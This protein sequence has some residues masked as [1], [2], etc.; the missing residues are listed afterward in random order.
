MAKIG[1]IISGIF[2]FLEKKEIPE[3]EDITE[4][5]KDKF[6]ASLVLKLNALGYGFDIIEAESN[7]KVTRAMKEM[8]ISHEHKKTTFNPVNK[9]HA[10]IDIFDEKTWE[11]TAANSI[12]N[13][14]KVITKL[15]ELKTKKIHHDDEKEPLQ[16]SIDYT[17]IARN[18]TEILDRE[19]LGDSI[20]RDREK[21]LADTYF[22]GNVARLRRLQKLCNDC[23]ERVITSDWEDIVWREN[24]NIDDISINEL[25]HT[26]DS[27]AERCCNYYG[28]E[29]EKIIP[30]PTARIEN[31]K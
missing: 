28:E 1:H 18:F 9:T 31:D 25:E 4:V 2:G 30:F 6:T 19:T 17:G 24:E 11:N 7:A 26:F 21:R 8:G 3:E 23:F 14:K 5:I 16:Y 22:D 13:I 20:V 12:D 27:M 15:S 10:Q 29:E